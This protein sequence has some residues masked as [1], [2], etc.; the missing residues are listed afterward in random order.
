MDEETLHNS[1][2]K[3]AY[4]IYIRRTQSEIWDWGNYGTAWDDWHQAEKEV[5][6]EQKAINNRVKDYFPL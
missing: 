3:R 4:E 6:L 5:L 2:K 1:V